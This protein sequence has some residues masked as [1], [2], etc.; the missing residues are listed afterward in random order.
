MTIEDWNNRPIED[1]LRTRIA[2]LEAEVEGLRKD[3]KY[4][5]D[6][7]KKCMY[8]EDGQASEGHK[9]CEDCISRHLPYIPEK[10]SNF[11]PLARGRG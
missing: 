6:W 10:P 5:P 8:S 11:K 3:M 7:C 1:D 2:E 4:G 9:K